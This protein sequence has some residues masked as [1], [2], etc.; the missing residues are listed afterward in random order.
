MPSVAL[1][2]LDMVSGH[3]ALFIIAPPK[4]GSDIWLESSLYKNTLNTFFFSFLFFI[5]KADLWRRVKSSMIFVVE[6]QV[7]PHCAFLHPGVSAQEF[8]ALASEGEEEED[9][10][11]PL[12]LSPHQFPLLP[13]SS[14]TRIFHSTHSVPTLALKW[15]SYL[16]DTRN[17]CVCLTH[18]EK[19]LELITIW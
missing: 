3:P 17:I 13:F 7:S 14:V 2:A 12:N 11:N 19:L 16:P 1:H 4:M 18:P 10:G 6:G 9:L 8:W 15:Y 5:A